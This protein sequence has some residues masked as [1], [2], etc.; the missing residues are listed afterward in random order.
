MTPEQRREAARFLA[1]ARRSGPPTPSPPPALTPQTIAEGYALQ[2]GVHDELEVAGFGA[3]VGHKIGCTTPVMQAFLGIDHPCAGAVFATTVFERSAELPLADYHRIGVECEVAARLAAD[4]P[5]QGG[6]HTRDSVAD[7]VDALMAGIELVDDRY[8]DYPGLSAPTLIADD[9]FN[10]G[11]V[12]GPEVAA[13]RDLDLEALEGV[14]TI[15]GA[16]VGRGR[17]ADILEH[18]LNALAW[19]ANHQVAR[20]MPL[21]A[22]DFVMLGSVVK[23]VFL[24]APATVDIRFDGLGTA[25]VRFV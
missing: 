2:D 24:D 9:F 23:T 19:L 16:E 1:Q 17:G 5:A 22:G 14:M 18:P 4:L 11:V 21:R 3:R 6:G 25:S 15:D 10:A 7:A 8:V 20:G 13:W 12:L